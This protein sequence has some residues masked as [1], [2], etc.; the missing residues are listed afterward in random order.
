MKK[1]TEKKKFKL[2]K[3]A[4]LT[5]AGACAVTALV[6]AVIPTRGVQAD[7]PFN[8]DT[9]IP[10]TVDDAIAVDPFVSLASNTYYGSVIPSDTEKHWAFPE[11]EGVEFKGHTYY[12]INR[13]GMFADLTVPVFEISTQSTPTA[14]SVPQ[15]IRNYVGGDASGYTPEGGILKLSPSVVYTKDS[16]VAEAPYIDLE[17]GAEAGHVP[18][19]W[20]R[21]TEEKVKVPKTQRMI[22]VYG[23]EASTPDCFYFKL[24]IEVWEREWPHDPAKQP[25]DPDYWT[26]DEP[27]DPIVG[28]EQPSYSEVMLVCKNHQIVQSIANGAFKDVANFSQM[29]LLSTSNGGGGS[30][31]IT[32]IGDYAFENCTRLQSISFGDNIERLGTQVFHNCT[33]LTSIDFGVTKSIGDGCFADCTMLTNLTLPDTLQ[34]IGTAAFMNCRSLI[35]AAPNY[36]SYVSEAD[37]NSNSVIFGGMPGINN[38]DFTVGSYAFCNCTNLETTKMCQTTKPIEGTY[39]RYGMYAGCNKLRYVELPHNTTG[40]KATP[41]MFLECPNLEC[42]RGNN[43]TVSA[44]DEEFINSV[45]ESYFPGKD[46]NVSDSFV[47]WGPNPN[48]SSSINMLKFAESNS[49]PY[50]YWDKYDN[51]FKYI[52]TLEDSYRFTFTDDFIVESIVQLPGATAKTI[53][54][55]ATIG[56]HPIQAIA[57][58]ACGKVQ[59]TK[60]VSN[61]TLPTKIEIA[62]SI[63][64]IG[65]NAFRSCESVKEVDFIHIPFTVSADKTSIGSNCFRDC[66]NL[67]TIKFRDDNFEG[68]G[69]FDV[70][71]DA[72]SVGTDAFLTE[73]PN[74]LKMYGRMEQGYWPYEYALDPNNITCS[75]DSKS[76]IT[77]CSG[78]PQNLSCRYDRPN[79]SEPGYVSLLSY[80]TVN[81][82]VGK[83]A[84]EDPPGSGIYTEEDVHIYDL[85]NDYVG[86][87]IL[88]PNQEAIINQY[89]KS[90]YV[91]YGITSIVNAQN[92]L[93]TNVSPD[94]SDNDY[95]I[96][97]NDYKTNQNYHLTNITFESLESLPD[98]GPKEDEAEKPFAE[99]LGLQTITFNGNMKSLGVLP[100]YNKAADLITAPLA[101]LTGVYFNGENDKE[102]ATIDDPY[103]WYDNGII[104]SYYRDESGNGVT[105]I[106]EVLQS[107][108]KPGGVGQAQ[109]SEENDPCI[110]D[111]TKIADAAFKNCDYIVSV[112]FSAS[113]DLTEIPDRCFNNCNQLKY[114]TLPEN[115]KRVEPS[116]QENDNLKD[117]YIYSKSINVDEDAFKN[118]ESTVFHAY[119]DSSIPSYVKMVNKKE[120]R[121]PA[122]ELI[123]EK[124]TEDPQYTIIFIDGI[125]YSEFYRETVPAGWNVAP[126][127]PPTH[128]NYVFE[129]FYSTPPNAWINVQQNATVYAKYTPVSTSSTTSS[130]GSTS[131]TSSTKKS[132]S[133]GGGGSS[134]QSS[135]SSRS[136]SI[137]STTVQPVIVSGTSNPYGAAGAPAVV[138]TAANTKSPATGGQTVGNVGKTKLISTTGGITDTSKMSATVNGSSD[139][140]VIKITETQEANDMAVQALTAAFGSLDAIRY[141]PI[142]ISLYDSTGTQKISPIPAGVTI[143]ITMPIPDNLAIYGGNAKIA[144]T[145][146]G[147]LDKIQPKFT[148]INGVPCMNYTVTHLSPYVVYV[149]TNNLTANGTLDATPKTGDPIHPKWFLVIGLAAVSGIMFLK[150]DRKETETAEAA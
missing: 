17:K 140:Y 138:N 130:S 39:G 42:V 98:M 92:D 27:E 6:V 143:N 102:S 55:P 94:M 84:V 49:L 23:D 47:I 1:V 11:G 59:G 123:Y 83:K 44:T 139:N 41:S 108:G 70:N 132:S 53:R 149:D 5:I 65:E 21:Y 73:N 36:P 77:Y 81:T 117:I 146:G 135:S 134:G 110:A 34:Q 96:R 121:T 99:C 85:I 111:V 125:D 113:K 82:V 144:C 124:M 31:G 119:E 32:Q 75:T 116:F 126:P 101:E 141:L 89:T 12:K 122:D 45:N 35:D 43:Y 62:D 76:Y 61:L 46:K 18:W 16:D 106:E 40:F 145:E 30:A 7:D 48:E 37:D 97:T 95:F 127:T 50:M 91:P 24:T 115:I 51:K 58:D 63:A 10:A 79:S 112:D 100:F 54:V 109:I 88:S 136:T 3:S 15:C 128:V 86:G 80:P 28:G 33:G 114:V 67:D 103:Y 29:E 118:T 93:G 20:T 147:T 133:G 13:E 38:N 19:K 150:R 2:K 57:D 4:R 72:S 60:Y 129:E 131:S 78:N 90:I 8:P 87:K 14:T 142:D 69:Y 104:Y 137:T 105:T 107:R 26:G 22:D 74:G 66:K 120:S 148:V 52:M 56:G 68:N 9:M 71:I 25:G 64:T